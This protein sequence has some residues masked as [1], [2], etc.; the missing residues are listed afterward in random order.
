VSRHISIWPFDSYFENYHCISLRLAHCM[1]AVYFMFV[2]F[3][4]R[5]TVSAPDMV[6]VLTA[7]DGE[8]AERLCNIPTSKI[9][10]S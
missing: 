9:N 4:R 10:C 7:L 5:L 1:T 6:C 3:V 2:M 8:A